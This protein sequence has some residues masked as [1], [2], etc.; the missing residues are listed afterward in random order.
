AATTIEQAR[1]GLPAALEELR[2]DLAAAADL[3]SYG[4]AELAT[5]SSNVRACPIAP[6]AARIAATA[7]P[8]SPTWRR[9]ASRP[10][11]ML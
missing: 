2:D 8:W 3:T 11:S 6:S 1:A 10:L 5:A 4:G 7:P 9:N